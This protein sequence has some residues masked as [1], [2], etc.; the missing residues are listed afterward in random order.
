MPYSIAKD[1]FAVLLFMH[2]NNMKKLHGIHWNPFN[3]N[4]AITYKRSEI[5]SNNNSYPIQTDENKLF[6]VT[7]FR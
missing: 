5:L 3:F 7:V 4:G 6:S 1:L 2:S